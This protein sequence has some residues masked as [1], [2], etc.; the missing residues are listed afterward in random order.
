MDDIVFTGDDLTEIQH[1]K[2][3]LDQ[4]LSIK[5]LG[6]L[7]FFLGLEIARSPSGIL[8]NQ[9]KYT[10][11][12]L[13]DSGLLAVKPCSTPYDSSLKLHDSDSP[14]Y[15]DESAFRRLIGRL[16]YL[17]TTRPDI[18][19]AVQQLS[20]FVSRPQIIH[21]QAATC[22]LKY[23]KS[24]PAKGLFLSANSPLKLYGFADSD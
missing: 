8:L 12:L 6:K 23:L 3:F 15:L 7:R 4:Q 11:N 9:R 20:Q 18:A 10:L 5:D 13:Y 17:T 2:S 14:L 19:F 22:V 1:V 21:F 24:C 16:L